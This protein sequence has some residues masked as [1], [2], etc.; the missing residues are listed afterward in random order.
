MSLLSS[1]GGP[2]IA[3]LACRRRSASKRRS[4]LASDRIEPVLIGSVRLALRCSPA[5]SMEAAHGPPPHRGS[6]TPLT[7]ALRGRRAARSFFEGIVPFHGD[8]SVS[9]EE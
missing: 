1:L 6:F 4:F 7:R 5:R 9:L 8:G 3:F 2:A